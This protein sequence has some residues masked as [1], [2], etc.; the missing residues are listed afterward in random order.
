MKLKR[1]KRNI[2][3]LLIL[4]FGVT[5]FAGNPDRQ[6]EAGASELLFNPW[7]RSAGLHSMSTS[8]V[9]GVEAMRLNVAG[10]GR[11]ENIEFS[12][13]NARLY[14][15]ADLGFNSFGFVKKV[16]KNGAFG[17]SMAAV[18]FGDISR[19]T[20]QLPGG[21]GGTFSPSFFHMGIGYSQTYENKISVGILFRAIS[22]SIPDVGA[23]GF[24]IDAGV[25]YVSGENDEF[26]LG[27]SLR[28][29]GSPLK[30]DGEGLSIQVVPPDGDGTITVQQRASPYEMPSVLNI[31]V[32]YDFAI[33]TENL[34]RATT[35]FTSNAFGRDQIGVGAEL[36]LFKDFAIRG[37][38]KLDFGDSSGALNNIYTGPAAGATAN[39]KLSNNF[40]LGI[41][42]AY[43]A[44]N[45]FKG[46]HN[47]SLRVTF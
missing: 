20:T 30:F 2:Y 12:A 16:G 35:N 38:Y 29:V 42:Y 5:L 25:Q 14:E 46:S 26:K 6:G 11:I 41:D 17:V 47:L 32:S 27:I 44:T 22:E 10:I 13:S 24:A 4:L 43:R 15:G 34:L 28:N 9:K 19:T 37:A 45:P 8:F 1:M 23:R 3:T 18:D 21:T 31:G 40:G 39:F 7:A 36:Y 33:G